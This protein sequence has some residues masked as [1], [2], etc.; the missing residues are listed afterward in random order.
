LLYF[1]TI[2]ARR[3]RVSARTD[4]DRPSVT[5]GRSTLPLL[6][7]FLFLNAI[8]CSVTPAQETPSPKT[9][10]V[11]S[12]FSDRSNFE[13]LEPF[14]S[15]VRSHLS[16]PVNFYVEYLESTRFA[17]PG[18]RESLSET[19]HHAY[20]GSR[21]DLVVAQAYPALL[22][23]LDYREQTFPG[24]PIVFVEVDPSRIQRTKIPIGVTG[25]TTSVDIRGSLDLALRLHPDTHNVV[26]ISGDSEFEQ[27]WDGLFR[28]QVRALPANL[29]LIEFSGLP[30]RLV[31]DRMSAV[32]AHTVVFAQIESQDSADPAFKVFDLIEAVSQRFPTY[33]IFN[34]CMD[35]GCVGG[36]Y[37][38]Q[39][40]EDGKTAGEMAARVLSGEKP[41]NIP[42]VASAENRAFVDWRQLRRWN[43]SEASLPSG[44]VVL[45]RPPSFWER[46]KWRLIA[47]ALFLVAQVVLILGLL[48]HRRRRKRAEDLVA[49]QRY[50][51][52][53]VSQISSELINASPMHI[54]SV[55]AK[56]LLPLRDFLGVDRISL[57]KLN[58]KEMSFRLRHSAGVEGTGT[59][60]KALNRAEYPWLFTRLLG[61]EPVVIP[62]LED[63]PGEAEAE[64]QLFREINLRTVMIFPLNVE[65]SLVGILSFVVI[66]AASSCPEDLLLQ[67]RALTQVYANAFARELSQEALSESETRF[68]VM[69][70]AAPAFIWMCD[71][72]GKFTYM[73]K[74]T[75]DFVG[76]RAEN[77]DG[78]G[79]FS[80]LHPEDLQAALETSIRALNRRDRF[81][82]EYRVLRH[83]GDYRWM[84]DIGNP[85]FDAEGSFIG[86]IGSAVDTTDQHAAREALEKVSGQLI[87]A[88]E[89]ERSMIA[90]EL[91]DDICQRLAMLSLRIEKITKGW[92]IGQIS[93]GDQL[94][95]IW[96][97]CSDLTGDVQ[98]L[99]HELHPSILDN[100]GLVTAVKSFFR[101][102]S[103]DSERTVEFT[104]DN[105]PNPL[106]REIALS[107]FRVVQEALHNSAKYSGEKHFEVHLQGK[108]GAIELEV[109]DRGV[110]FDVASAKNAGGLGL[111][112]M[113]ERVHILNGTFT[114]ESKPDAGTRIRACVPLTTHSTALSAQ[115]S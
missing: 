45:N 17:E 111:V 108:P 20:A 47:I 55:I 67:L 12:S 46:Y 24:V 69:G 4:R 29:K 76:A 64:R 37:P 89:K 15:S 41:E 2:S 5:P 21:I 63:L 54:G 49:R 51:E 112:S 56:S 40:E 18:Y 75:V 95:Q 113:A 92:S 88:Q 60:P 66:Q 107:L 72:Y 27:Y 62:G 82:R 52:T 91:H 26:L 79:W 80:Y 33:S 28:E 50:F 65:N 44:T 102:F 90:R 58:N 25:I 85:R 8:F 70:D 109:S 39:I 86:F 16:V 13:E 43:I 19:I 53:L 35:H 23:A 42:I 31:F 78:N 96:Q 7:F 38:D 9:I 93:V 105:V 110:G 48:L 61:T 104:H 3:A 32:P 98:A 84:L 57:F 6:C 83:D 22:L 59:A 103:E 30:P 10:L 77:L 34:Y 99:S 14:K 36:S 11:L 94:E 81:I 106:P 87:D 74:K 115:M 73:N 71:Q 114:I 101:E 97:Q 100:L 1:G 68:Q